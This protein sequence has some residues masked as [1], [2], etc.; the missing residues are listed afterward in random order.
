LPKPIDISK[1]MTLKTLADVRDL[2][3]KHLPAGH[4]QKETW[5]NVDKHMTAAAAGGDIVLCAVS[6]R[7]VLMFE[8]VEHT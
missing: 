7:M 8:R 1:V 5:Q 4:R 6:L 3:E 2:V